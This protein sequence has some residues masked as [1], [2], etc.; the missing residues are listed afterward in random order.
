[1]HFPPVPLMWIKLPCNFPPQP[2]H[3]RTPCVL[4]DSA[5]HC[6]SGC[7]PS[8]LVFETSVARLTGERLEETFLNWQSSEPTDDPGYLDS[9]VTLASCL[10]RFDRSGQ[11]LEVLRVWCRQKSNWTE[12]QSSSSDHKDI[13][14]LLTYWTEQQNAYYCPCNVNI[15]FSWFS[16]S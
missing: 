11:I 10:L 9:P 5:A 13:V 8:A 2:G 3:G 14:G 12:F 1:M 16:I 7:C 6:F 4:S 15:S